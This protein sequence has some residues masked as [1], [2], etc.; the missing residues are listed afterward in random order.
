MNK[1]HELIFAAKRQALEN[2]KQTA[3]KTVLCMGGNTLD[4]HEDNLILSK[5]H[6]EDKHKIQDNSKCELFDNV[7]MHKCTNVYTIHPICGGQV[8]TVY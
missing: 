6:P 3:K 4:I 1:Q 2:I 5:D 8:C 7:L